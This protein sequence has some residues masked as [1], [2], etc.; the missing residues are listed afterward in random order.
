MTEF[1]SNIYIFEDQI[2]CIKIRT[3]TL[4]KE[5]KFVELTLLIKNKDI[6]AS[7]LAYKNLGGRHSILTGEKLNKLK[8]STFSGSKKKVGHTTNCCS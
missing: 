5:A 4:T 7:I 3:Y 2:L 1:P 6:V 8:K